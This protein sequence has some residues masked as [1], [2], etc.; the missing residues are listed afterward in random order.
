MSFHE[1]QPNR[2]HYFGQPN[3][4]RHGAVRLD[5]VA[6]RLLA[7]D[8]IHVSTSGLPSDQDLGCFEIGDDVSDRALGDAD[9]LGQVA[10]AKCVLYSCRLGELSLRW[11]SCFLVRV[12]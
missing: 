6:Q 7:V 5:R 10:D 2:F 9:L 11:N 4:V 12:S 8:F 3:E 1:L